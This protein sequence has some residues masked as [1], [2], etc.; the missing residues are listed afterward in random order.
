MLCAV[1]GSGMLVALDRLVLMRNTRSSRPP[2]CPYQISEISVCG[3]VTSWSS[4]S[5]A[6]IVL[7]ARRIEFEPAVPL[8]VEKA[9]LAVEELP[10]V[11]DGDRRRLGMGTVKHDRHRPAPCR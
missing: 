6:G 2:L 7:R 1:L 11:L 5:Q 8:F 4:S 9:G 10:H 3:S